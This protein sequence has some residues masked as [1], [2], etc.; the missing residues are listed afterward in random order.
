M[1][2]RLSDSK[3]FLDSHNLAGSIGSKYLKF[4]GELMDGL[5][6]GMGV[7]AVGSKGGFTEINRTLWE[8]FG[9][10]SE[11][12]FLR[13]PSQN[14]YF[15]PEE[16]EQFSGLCEQGTVK[17]FET[18]FRRKDGSPFWGSIRA[19]PLKGGTEGM[20][21]LKIFEDVTERKEQ[22]NRLRRKKEELAVRNR[23]IQGIFQS[24]DLN[25]R[26]NHI[27]DEVMALSKMEIG[28]IYLTGERG[29]TIRAWHGFSEDFLVHARYFPR[30]KMPKELQVITLAAEDLDERGSIPNFAKR[31]G[32]QTWVTLPLKAPEKSDEGAWV[33]VV[34]LGSRRYQAIDKG[35]LKAVQAFSGQMAL[36]IDHVRQ[37]HNAR[38]RLAR[39]RVLREID[40]AII[41]RHS[42]RNVL[43]LIL[44]N[45]PAG[46]GADAVAIS[47][48]D[49]DPLT[50]QVF[51]MRLPNGTVIE[52]QAFELTENLLHWLVE[53]R[54]PVIIHDLARDSR[55]QMHLDQIHRQKLAS[56]LGVPLVSQDKVI[57]ILHIL[58]TRL[59]VFSDEDLAFFTT[60]A[61][62]AAIGIDN[63]RLIENLRIAE[64]EYRRLAE[65]APDIIYHFQ[66]FPEFECRYISPSVTTIAGYSPEEFYAYPNLFLR[67]TPLND[68]ELKKGI[69]RGDLPFDEPL[70]VRCLKKDGTP[71]WMEHRITPVFDSFG[72]LTA[73]HGIARD[74]S[75]RKRAEGELRKLNAELERR[76]L[77]RTREL[78][79]AKD[80]AETASRAKS[81]F[82]SNMSHEIRTPLNAILGFTQLLQRDQTL[83]LQQ[84]R[85]VEIIS[86]SGEHLLALIN[87]IL[88]ISRIESGHV[89]LNPTVF[90]L[91]KLIEDL[92]LMSRS[93]IDAKG[94]TLLVEVAADVPQYVVADEGK[95]RQIFNNILGNAVKFTER[96][97]VIMRVKAKRQKK[98][99]RN[100]RLIV[101]IED[102]GPGISEEDLKRL[103]RPFEQTA[104]G[105]KVGGT[106]LGLAISHR[107]VEVM[108]G[109][110]E[111]ESEL[112]K[113]SC[114]RF[115]V[116]VQEVEAGA[117]K[118]VKEK[119]TPIGSSALRRAQDLCVSLLW[120]TARKIGCS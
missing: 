82:L 105:E 6:L 65:N 108:N 66:I 89:A 19:F 54:E 24:F 27:L 9:Y 73:I 35:D 55:V 68:R 60:L 103:F 62:Q 2:E 69:I 3:G 109:K 48:F 118:R 22:E 10:S 14:H 104:A 99:E 39:L 7:S 77:E 70:L 25:E 72:R 100:I 80:V 64:E 41:S 12:E 120:M 71:N 59:K 43:R 78:Q 29:V 114:F 13:I 58:T 98:K 49:G 61:G 42:I 8:M 90:S 107:L 1:K 92:E 52:E 113:G 16:R 33:G 85:S 18:R 5:S 56:Y 30:D 34:V 31:E 74:V 94:L 38:E 88:E 36:A 102:T 46:L 111:V 37:Y 53:K 57:G 47:L 91:P 51:I 23:V 110:I 17:D 115:E 75:E 67:I 87:D 119:K 45:I 112:G 15:N 76:V 32:I 101:E 40:R 20:W 21:C 28:G 106:G 63:M 4:L 97:G 117:V 83:G 93:R 79:K 11:R 84:R 86:R 96:G 81:A 26:L 44:S 50:P 95:L 116:L